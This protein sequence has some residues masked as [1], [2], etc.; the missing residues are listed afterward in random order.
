LIGFGVGAVA[1]LWGQLAGVFNVVGWS[2]VASYVFFAGAYGVLY[3]R[4][5]A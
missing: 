1:L 2:L 3:L 5:P 4:R